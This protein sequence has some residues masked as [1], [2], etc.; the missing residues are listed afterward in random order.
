M[1]R[2]LLLYLSLFYVVLAWALNTVLAKQAVA[3]INPLAFTFLRFLAMTPLAFLL[4]RVAGQRVHAYRRDIAALIVCGACGYG[5]YQY[6]WIVGLKNTTPFASALLAATSPILTLAIVAVLGHE[7]VRSG[8]WL[9]A[10]IAL[11]GIAI[12]EGAFS[13]ATSFRIGDVLTLGASVV[14]AVYNVVSARLLDRYTP[15]ELLAVTMAIGTVMLAPG[16]IPALAH[17]DFA[18]ITWDVW[19]RLIYATLF[20]ILLTYPVWS[21]GISTLGAGPA[22]VFSF[23]VPVLTG[24]LS[25]PIVH[26]SFTRYELTGAAICLAG[27]IVS[28]ALGRISLTAIW[29]Q[30]TLPFER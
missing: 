2:R 13:G 6:F 15:L 25:V 4:V 17:T 8:R 16:G 23:L 28:Y 22:S 5:V 24:I 18:A 1:P 9:G 10:G 11:F 7:R 19:W 26:A 20:P 3:Q 30:R 12:F 21:Y 14:F 29:A 27:M